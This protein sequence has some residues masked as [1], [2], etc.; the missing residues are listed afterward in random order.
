LRPQL[1][2]E[3]GLPASSPLPHAEAASTHIAWAWAA[4][5]RA[6][7]VAVRQVAFFA[8]EAAM[9]LDWPE[10]E[11][12]LKTRWAR[13]QGEVSAGQPL[14]VGPAQGDSPDV[15]LALAVEGPGGLRAVAGVALVAPCTERTVQQVLLA[16]PWLQWAWGRREGAQRAFGAHMLDMLA[17]VA[18]HDNARMAAQDWLN[19]SVT[20][21]RQ[22][23]PDGQAPAVSLSCFHVDGGTPRWW[24]TSETAW[25]E[26]GAPVVEAASEL[27]AEAAATLQEVD[28]AQGWAW[29]VI[30]DGEAVLVLVALFDAA[31]ASS[32]ARP[33]AVGVSLRA[34]VALVEPLLRRWHEA[35][36]SLPAHAWFSLREAVQ[37]G[38]GPGNWRWKAGGVLAVVTALVLGV[39]PVS[40]RI[41]A[42]TVIEGQ[43]RQVVSAPFDGFV[44]Q[45][46][47][48][49]GERVQEGQELASLDDRDIRLD[50]ATQRSAR[51]QAA[52]KVRQAL[53]D[54]DMGA[55]AQAQAELQQAEAQLNLADTRLARV[56]LRA[57]M[58]G[59]VVSG[60]WSQQLGTPVASGK[61][62]FEL[63]DTGGYRVVLH[64][65]DQDI[66]QV[67]VGQVGEVRLTGH[68]ETSYPL[69]ISRVTAT[70]SVQDSV[71][72]FR[73]EAQWVGAVPPLSPGM[74]GVGKIDA[75]R[76]TL[77]ERWTR[78]TRDWLQLKLWA[79]W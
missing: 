8:D 49:A 18:S 51:D 36:R 3:R 42:S 28:G 1:V 25:A 58:S 71:N 24:A 20:L 41:S 72:G 6:V 46:R 61:E 43:R 23:W 63:A 29:P 15:L 5:L 34:S 77:L 9:V 33:D 79:W 67:K 40:D 44:A 52:A 37:L 11:G 73:V 19:R 54:R 38:V 27:A 68:P 60:D 26:T 21:V 75:G 4:R 55:A 22:A 69:R 32:A 70:A 45:V 10:A 2:G 76:T 13:L 35:E 48:R 65:A 31:G 12:A 57:P 74:Q 14:C 66:T 17:H 64:V 39:W 53:A 62:M 78:P 7:G 50:Q 30:E 59:L 16:V 47:V 56:V